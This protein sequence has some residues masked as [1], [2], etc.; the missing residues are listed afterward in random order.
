MLGWRA[1]RG[2]GTS[3]DAAFAARM[4]DTSCRKGL[5]Q[6]CGDLGWLYERGEGV[7]RDERRG[8]ELKARDCEPDKDLSPAGMAAALSSMTYYASVNAIRPAPIEP[9]AADAELAS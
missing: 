1:L 5:R 4:F 7:P 9:F 3:R 2:E 6:A 8:A